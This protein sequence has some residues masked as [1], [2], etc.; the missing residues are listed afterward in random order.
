MAVVKRRTHVNSPIVMNILSELE[1]IKR[2]DY[3]IFG[4]MAM[5]SRSISQMTGKVHQRIRIRD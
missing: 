2:F 4:A 3:K 1:E 5:S